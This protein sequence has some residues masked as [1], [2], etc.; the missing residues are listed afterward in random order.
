MDLAVIFWKE[1]PDRIGSALVARLI[2]KSMKRE[3]KPRSFMGQKLAEELDANA[4]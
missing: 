4:R 2:Y 1:C 3:G